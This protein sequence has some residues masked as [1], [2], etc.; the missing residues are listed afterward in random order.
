VQF[1]GVTF[2]F[3]L[4]LNVLTCLSNIVN[5]GELEAEDG[6]GLNQFALKFHLDGMR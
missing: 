4:V 6:L 2:N 3:E 5:S 1:V